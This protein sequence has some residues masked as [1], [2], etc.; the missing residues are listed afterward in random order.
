MHAEGCVCRLDPIKTQKGAPAPFFSGVA[1]VGT[2][3]C[4]ASGQIS[5]TVGR[6]PFQYADR[7][8]GG[9]G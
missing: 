3:C 6:I 5:I 7:I 2:F 4:S 8:H 9:N 1:V